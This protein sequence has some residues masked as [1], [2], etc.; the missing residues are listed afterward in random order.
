MGSDIIARG[1]A[2]L[3]P[4][5]A[6]WLSLVTLNGRVLAESQA[7]VGDGGWQASLNVPQ[8]VSGT[9]YFQASI[10]DAGGQVL[11]SNEI[12]VYLVLDTES[13]DRYL[14][15]YRP[16]D[17]DP[18]MAGF[19]LFF[20][21]RAERP[22][23]SSVTISVWSDDCQ[24]QVARQSFVLNGSGYWQGFVIIPATV[25]GPGCAIA[26]F[27]TAGEESWREVQVPINITANDDENGA[28]VVI[29]NPPRDASFTAGQEFLIYGTA[30]NTSE[31]PVRVTVLL[32][33]GRIISQ[34]DVM[35]DYFGYWEQLVIIPADISGP[36]S[37]AAS[38][39]EPGDAD[40]AEDQ[41]V[42]NIRP[43]PTPS[44]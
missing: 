31:Q 2:Q 16:V 24:T 33:N 30:L 41:T 39:G 36:A 17:G 22:V 12:P 5:D 29:G 11:A 19:N 34:N 27:G 14:A 28:G 44:P 4:S 18:A 42:I 13:T 21:G 32:E 37:I 38:A 26:H 10:R 25:S 40:Y 6:A 15:L 7:S 35:A 20:D 23:D 1:L 43:A 9:A 3:G 8:S